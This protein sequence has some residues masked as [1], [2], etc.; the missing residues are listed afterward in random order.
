MAGAEGGSEEGEMSRSIKLP[1]VMDVALRNIK[2]AKVCP[3]YPSICFP[4]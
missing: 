2:D 3:L 1:L 4:P